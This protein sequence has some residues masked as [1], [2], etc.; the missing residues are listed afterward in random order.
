MALSP[1]YFVHDESQ[2]YIFTLLWMLVLGF[3]SGVLLYGHCRSPR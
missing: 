1:C 2:E 3:T